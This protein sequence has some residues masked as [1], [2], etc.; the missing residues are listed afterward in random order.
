MQ[1][2]NFLWILQK[3]WLSYSVEIHLF[4]SSQFYQKA[5]RLAWKLWIES[6]IN[7]ISSELVSLEKSASQGRK[8]TEVNDE[9]PGSTVDSWFDRLRKKI[10][11][12]G[13]TMDKTAGEYFLT[14]G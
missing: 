7:G 8:N 14:F 9:M 13:L 12:A 3:S 2:F 10:V 11:A 1:S 5:L 6:W 4:K